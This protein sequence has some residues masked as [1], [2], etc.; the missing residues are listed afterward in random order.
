MRSKKP[1]PTKSG[2]DPSKEIALNSCTQQEETKNEGSCSQMH[3]KLDFNTLD[4]TVNVSDLNKQ[5][6]KVNPDNIQEIVSPDKPV[7]HEKI[8]TECSKNSGSCKEKE[9]VSDER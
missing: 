9:R 1:V 7:I 5:V 8:P 3:E 4:I 6:Q 2:K